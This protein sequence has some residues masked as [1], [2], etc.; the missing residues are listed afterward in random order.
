MLALDE[1]VLW[2]NADTP[3]KTATDYINAVKKEPGKFKMGG[4]GSK[5]EDQIITAEIEQNTGAK[6]TYVPYKGGGEVAVQLVGKHVDST[7][8]NPIE[9][10]AQWRAGTLRPLCVFDAQRMPYKEK[11]TKD[12][13]WNDIPTC[14]ESGLPVEYTMLRGIFMP[15]GV[16]KE[17][18]DFYVDLLKKVRATP[19]WKTFSEQAAFNQTF[20]TGPEYVKWVTDAEAKHRQ[21][22]E[23]AGFLASK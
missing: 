3:Y 10:V 2:V 8:N 16:P 17:A 5:Q 23:K 19:D 7:V 18:V 4:T 15:A 1:F 21:L 11:V 22:M 12:M 9:A 20:M 6:F 14:K 13:S